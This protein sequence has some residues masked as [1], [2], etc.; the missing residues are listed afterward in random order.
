MAWPCFFP[1]TRLTQKQLDFVAELYDNNT[2]VLYSRRKQS[3]TLFS[4]SEE[5]KIA[6][7]L[8]DDV[9]FECW[10]KNIFSKIG[11]K[12]IEVAHE[13]VTVADRTPK[14]AILQITEKTQKTVTAVAKTREGSTVQIRL[15]AK[16]SL[17][18]CYLIFQ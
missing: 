14:G 7:I 13:T 6:F 17:V 5:I 4:S 3:N 18:Y 10:Y 9:S 12:D 1:S 16:E 15:V 11:A 2:M 8:A